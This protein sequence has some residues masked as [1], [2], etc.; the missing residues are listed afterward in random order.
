MRI[1]FKFSYQF[2]SSEQSQGRSQI[3]FE[4]GFDFFIWGGVVLKIFSQKPLR[5]H[6]LM[7]SIKKWDF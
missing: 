3:F 2:I 4:G 1:F 5:G 7:T 6:S